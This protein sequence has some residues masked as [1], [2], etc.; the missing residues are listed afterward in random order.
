MRII[1]E[2]RE[3]EANLALAKKEALLFFGDDCI[4][5]EKFLERPRHVEVQ[6]L[7]D[8]EGNVIHLG[9]RDCSV[10]RNHQKLLEETPSPIL[11][12]PLR[13]AMTMARASLLRSRTPVA[14]SVTA[15]SAV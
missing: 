15:R 3:L 8:G 9:E 12:E 1:R 7:G 5:M 2:E 6:L 10:Q 14:G 4:H 11:D 13:E